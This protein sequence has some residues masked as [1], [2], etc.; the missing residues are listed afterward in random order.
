MFLDQNIN[1][2]F[3]DGF[4]N[5]YLSVPVLGEFSRIFSCPQGM[6]T[7]SNLAVRQSGIYE[8]LTVIGT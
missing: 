7:I 1:F 6:R 8:A 3:S 4:A 2:V 5:S